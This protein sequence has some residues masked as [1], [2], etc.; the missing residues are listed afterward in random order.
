MAYVARTQPEAT[1][2]HVRQ[3]LAKRA[4]R[5]VAEHFTA[6]IE[7]NLLNGRVAVLV[8]DYGKMLLF[9]DCD[10]RGYPITRAMSYLSISDF[11]PLT[12]AT[13]DT[14][15]LQDLSLKRKTVEF[16]R[17]LIMSAEIGEFLIY[18]WK[19]RVVESSELSVEKLDVKYLMGLAQAAI[20]KREVIVLNEAQE[21]KLIK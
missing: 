1:N 4:A 10:D 12:T 7:Q 21:N 5:E 18:C 8:K 2:P 20:E 15:C 14:A 3:Y 9:V 19:G 16:E 17:P 6:E 13:L 11:K